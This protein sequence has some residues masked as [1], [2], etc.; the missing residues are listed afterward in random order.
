MNFDR[1]W[2]RKLLYL[3]GIIL[4]LLPLAYL[5]QPAGKASDAAGNGGGYA[6]KLAQLRNEYNLSTANLGEIDPAGATMQQLLFG[7]NCWAVSQLSSQAHEYQKKED[8]ENLRATLE[9]ILKL[10]PN[11][12]KV[13]DFQ[14]HNLSYNLSVEYDDYRARYKQVTVGFN[15]LKEGI[16]LNKTE[17]RLP[18]KLAWYIGHKI[19]RADEKRLYRRLFQQDWMN[20]FHAKD[21]PDRPLEKRDNWLV[22]KDKF[23]EATN[24]ADALI[25]RGIPLKTTTPYLFYKETAWSQISYAEA[26]MEEGQ[27]EK[28]RPAWEQAKQDLDEFSNRKFEIEN[29]RVVAT[30]GEL[31]AIDEKIAEL[32][33]QL[34]NLVPGE[35]ER[36]TAEKIA[37]VSD[38]Q[39]RAALLKPKLQRTVEEYQLAGEHEHEVKVT[40]HE[41]A[42]Q[43]VDPA[44]R[45]QAKNLANEI[46][47][48]EERQF[49][50]DS[51]RGPLNY[52]YWKTRVIVENE[53][54]MRATHQHIYDAKQLFK[55]G[56]PH[57]SVAEYEKAWC[58]WRGILN[59]FP[60]LRNDSITPEEINDDIQL[61]RKSLQTAQLKFPENFV[62]QDVVDIA[63]KGLYGGTVP[64]PPD[65][66]DGQ[67]APEPTTAAPAVDPASP[68]GDAPAKSDPATAGSDQTSPEKANPAKAATE[69]APPEGPT[70]APQSADPTPDSVSPPAQPT[71]TLPADQQPA[72]KSADESTPTADQPANSTPATTE[73]VPATSEPVPATPDTPAANPK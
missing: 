31:E 4:L 70:P 60:L 62:L 38:P 11:Y 34:D 49:E 50:V 10:Q 14:A 57:E 58:L 15:F 54:D 28:G 59:R 23:I 6:G 19:G 65:C 5:G 36:L 73:S 25:D 51:M 66:I 53:P 17:A 64:F 69:S 8:W 26:L 67:P 1:G 45:T 32:S 9:Q 44:V 27:L 71:D 22:A 24:Q 43:A 37:A 55:A 68:A 46:I 16:L 40:W 47:R 3:G 13:W 2:Q 63:E 48:Q 61:Y 41:L 30:V 35:R 18:H 12:W 39:A 33:K 72:E 20:L 56:K 29:T 52:N 7:M 21:D 42:D